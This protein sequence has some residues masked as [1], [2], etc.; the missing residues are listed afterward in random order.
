MIKNLLTQFVFI[1]T[2]LI[3][4]CNSSNNTTIT[5]YNNIDQL[6]Q[7]EKDNFKR[8]LI[9]YIGK[10]P[11]DASEEN[12][13]HAY[14]NPH[15]E[16]QFQAHELTHYHTT[17]DRTYFVFTR[18]APSIH[19]KKVALGGYVRLD[20]ESNVLFIEELFRT[21]K[22]EPD[23]LTPKAGLLF[24][25][26]VSGSSLTPYYTSTTGKTDYIE[27]P[28]E[29]VWYDT[30]SF[31]WKTS[32]EDVLKEFMDAKVERTKEKIKAFEANR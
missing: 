24:N 6:S 31:T 2:L 28:N 19:L 32:R 8:A 18:I 3:S 16:K 30:S 10:K 11:E 5:D 13:F 29:E 12:K 20:K 7:D 15:Y 14:F 25:K 21:W 27:F 22:F 26:M 9:K 17:E 1:V 4:S 23:T